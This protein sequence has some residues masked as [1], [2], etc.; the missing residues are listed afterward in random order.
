[1]CF[2][3][4]I[5]NFIIK[6]TFNRILNL[7]VIVNV[8]SWAILSSSK[9]V[10]RQNTNVG[11]CTNKMVDHDGV[12]LS[13][14]LYSLSHLKPTFFKKKI[15]PLKI[16][17]ISLVI[18]C[19]IFFTCSLLTKHIIELFCAFL[20]KYTCEHKTIILVASLSLHLDFKNRT[21]RVLF[22]KRERRRN[23]RAGRRAGSQQ[24]AR[25]CCCPC[26]SRR[27]K[28]ISNLFKHGINVLIKIQL[29][30][31]S[32]YDHLIF[33]IRYEVKTSN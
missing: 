10:L 8:W 27:M 12:F 2:Y 16:T 24:K 29:L 13:V 21:Q 30:Q 7:C 25:A 23:S 6:T 3:M 15:N 33:F 4:T 32:W 18:K 26:S 28:C 20:F 1:M 17:I 19:V 11:C 31:I 9:L 5:P 14:L 22:Y